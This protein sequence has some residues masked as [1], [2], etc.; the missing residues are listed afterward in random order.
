MK[1]TL[2][3]IDGYAQI[4]RAYFAIRGGMRSSVTGEATHATFGFAGMLLKLLGPLACEYAVVAIDAPG[5]TF[6]DELFGEYKGTRNA[7][8]DDLISQI[9]RILE[10]IDCFGIPAISEPGLE[11]DDVI[12]TI[13]RR[14]L[15]DPALSDVEIRIVSKDKDLEQLLCERVVMYD[16]HTETLTD[17]AALYENKGIRPDQVI[18][19]LALTGDTVD[20]VPGIDGIGTKTAAALIQEFG[21]IDG[22]LA[23]LDKIKGKRREN[24][25][26]GMHRLPLSRQLVTLKYD[27]TFAFDLETARIPK[28]DPNKLIPLFKQLAFSRYQ[29]DVYR[30]AGTEP[31]A[32][33]AATTAVLESAPPSLTDSLPASVAMAAV[34]AHYRAVTT[35]E[36]LAELVGTLSAQPIIAFDTE[37]TGLERDAALCG[38][39]FAWQPGEAVYVPTRSPDPG[40]HLDTATVLEAL[41]PL[42]ESATVA[43]CGHNLKFDAR[44]LLAHGIRVRGIV[45][46][47]FLASLLIDPSQPAHN[48]DHLAQ[49]RLGYTMMPLTSLLGEDKLATIDTVALDKV[50]FYA[51]EDADIALRLYG[52]LKPLIDEMGMA[53]LMADVEAPL[54]PVIARM[55]MNGIVCDPD[56]LVRQGEILQG[57][58]DELRAEVQHVAGIVFSLDSP[59]QLADVLFNQLAF[60]P[61]KK[62]QTGF[63]TDVNELE[64]LAGLEDAADPKTSVPRLIIEYRMLTKLIGTYLGNLRSSVN[65]DTGR[66]HTTYHQIY[67]ATGRLASSAPN[68]QNIPVRTD[69]GRQIRKA[70]L[71]PE[72]YSL[73]CADY[74]QIELR[75]LA[76]FSDDPALLD[77][78]AQD[79]DIH[80]AVAS[81]VFGVPLDEVSREQ[82]SQ[83]KTINF[84]IIYGITPF[85]LSR[86]IAGLDVGAATRLIDGYRERFP[87]IDRFLQQCVQQAT[88]NGYVSTIMGRRRSIPEIAS[89]MMKTRALGERLAINSVIQGS[90]AD[91]IKVAMVNVQNRIDRDDLPLKLLLQ[92]HDELVLESPTGE[93][94]AMAGIVQSEME[95]AMALKVPLRSSA[96]I[97]PDWLSAK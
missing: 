80:A 62:T 92:I 35:R 8:P 66:I 17:V 56:E 63:S 50:T 52:V 12:A 73:I 90:A 75:V 18:D 88:E 27:G 36:Q 3:L 65:A 43:K 39:S 89:T 82:L 37:T 13:V 2:Y 15:D 40:A 6:R 61:G 21:G 41:K 4:F 46:D 53:V 55:E 14:V 85:G 47:S 72:G 49:T 16:I 67:T 5:P 86:R 29:A 84:G 78:F 58:V 97:G 59:K 23:N 26:A 60:K 32:E 54:T 68:L 22:I 9:P 44:I 93:A 71:A 24:I 81:Q 91:L 95:S 74:S 76:H 57:R 48:L 38:L 7:T 79:L 28:P 83:A 70:F 94:E 69:T 96:G 19:L 87:G 31:V 51:A 45:F 33:P 25:E 20:N 11:A 34:E 42:L 1:R 64:R 10:L 77:A 30:L